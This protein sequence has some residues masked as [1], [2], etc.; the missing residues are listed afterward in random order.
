MFELLSIVIAF[1]GSAAAGFW[2]LKTT[3]I[4][5]K[6]P[7]LMI[8]CGIAIAIA[9]S[10]LA[11][12]YWPL[13]SSAIAG[14]SFLVFGFFMYYLGQWGGGDAKILSAIG[15]LLPTLPE[16]FSAGLAFP[17]S[18]SFLFNV[19]LI[20]AAYML[21]Y[22]LVFALMNKKLISQFFDDIKKSQKIIFFGSIILFLVFLSLNWFLSVYL[23]NV[24]NLASIVSNSLLLLAASIGLFLIFKFAKVVED[25]GFKKKIPI[26]KLKIGDV[27]LDSKVFEGI[28]E[29]ELKKIKKSGK[30][31][32]WVKEG[33]RFGLAFPLALLFTLFVGD[34]IFL[35][36]KIVL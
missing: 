33:V 10:Y 29:K 22:A 28:T 23:N 4:P 27:L 14:G 8:A 19:F 26:S 35:L 24:Y 18:I 15:F 2:D 21:V 11:S 12:S 1:V 7:H 6:I 3:E 32:L 9:E 17:F 13:L 20:G 36:L 5:D 30:K 25:F 31:F 34:G 16:N